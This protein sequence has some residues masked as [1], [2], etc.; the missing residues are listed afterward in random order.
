MFGYTGVGRITGNEVGSVGG[1]G[2]IASRWG[3]TGWNRLFLSEF[4][5][6][7]SWLIPAALILMAA[8]L[9]ITLRV[10]RADLARASYLMWGGSLLVTGAV[11]SFAQGIIHPYYSIALAPAVGAL[12]GSGSVELWKRRDNVL[13]RLVLAG[14]VAASAAWAYVLLD[15]S[16]DWNPGLKVGILV[17]GLAAGALVGAG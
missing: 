8:G 6:Q 9:W 7:I 17:C 14:A 5:G 1:I 10:Q 16:P 3:L 13:A 2:G 11:F 4:G 12:V 15:R